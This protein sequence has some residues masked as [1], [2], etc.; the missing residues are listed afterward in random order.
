LDEQPEL[1]IWAVCFFVFRV[2]GANGADLG[3][4]RAL[5]DGAARNG[6]H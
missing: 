6:Y 1:W 2:S 5:R 3:S 4:R